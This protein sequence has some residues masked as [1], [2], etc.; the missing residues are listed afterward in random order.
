MHNVFRLRFRGGMKIT[1]DWV[2][3]VDQWLW[4]MRTWMGVDSFF[5]SQTSR[6]SA[7]V[8]VTFESSPFSRC[9]LRIS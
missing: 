6:K 7:H 3:A 1:N 4:A 9:V 5:T 2:D 8:S